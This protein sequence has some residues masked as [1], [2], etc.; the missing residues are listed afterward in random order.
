[1]TS[2]ETLM[3]RAL[4]AIGVVVAAI[5][6][7]NLVVLLWARHEFTPA[8]SI[9]A[10]HSNML[11]SGEGI[12]YD[13]N[14]YP[15]TVSPYGPVFYAASA[16]LHRAGLPLLQEGRCIS[17]AAFLAMLWLVWRALG[18]LGVERYARWMGVLLVGVTANLLFWATTGQVDALAICFSLATFAAFLEGRL[19]VAGAFAILAFFTKQTAL[20]GPATVAM[21]LALAARGESGGSANSGTDTEFPNRE[22]A[23]DKPLVAADFRYP[24]PNWPSRDFRRGL[25]GDRKRSA[26]WIPSVA[27]VGLI[28]GLALNAATHGH[29]F[30]DAFFANATSFPFTWDKMAGQLRY[31][32]LTAGALVLVA[33]VGVRHATRSTA[34]A[35]VYFAFAAGAWLSTGAKIVG[36][37]NYQMEATLAL[38]ICAACALDAV[39]FFPRVFAGDRGWIPLLQI[40]LLL[41][42]TLNAILAARTV[43]ER[44]MLE[45]VKRTEAAALAP[46]FGGPGDRVLSSQMDALVH[47][48]GRLEVETL[49]YT[50]LVRAGSVDP[51]PVR[52]DL[53]AGR[54]HAV[55]LNRDV[56]ATEA[57]QRYPELL[58]LPPSELEEIRRHYRLV[59]HVPGAYLDGDFVYQPR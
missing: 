33:A 9:V 30:A 59:A 1:V 26:I 48:R 20:A 32:A 39:R 43:A 49:F 55:I 40:P 41:Y 5:L 57:P 54:F 58:L 19:W 13:L 56:F 8:E 52:R 29:Y 27:G 22:A 15:Y 42:L 7:A 21:C 16:A 6:A 46:F 23:D 38:C 12:Y 25:A 14:R 11:A 28:A 36:D 24:S 3:R 50:L 34:R 53:A 10:L 47:F 37:L 4:A 31:F 2:R 17:F 18:S 45:P 35:Y 51:E 44:A